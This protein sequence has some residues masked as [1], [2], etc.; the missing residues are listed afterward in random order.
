MKDF[1][2]LVFMSVAALS[3]SDGARVRRDE[4]YTTKYDNL[5]LDEILAS[6]RL[7]NNY[8]RCLL[9]TGRCT[10]DATTLKSEY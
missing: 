3:L 9:D 10:S 6:D 2:A 7:V 8:V 1:V 4:K 5:N